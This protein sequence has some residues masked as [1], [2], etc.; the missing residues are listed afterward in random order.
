VNLKKSGFRYGI[1]SLL[2]IFSVF[3][4][5]CVSS[6]SGPETGNGVLITDFKPEFQKVYSGE[7]V[8]FMLRV[9]NIGSEKATYSKVCVVGLGNE[10]VENK[11]LRDKTCTDCFNFVT[12]EGFELLPPTE[13]VEGEEKV[14]VW[15]YTA[16]TTVPNGMKIPYTAIGRIYYYYQ[17]TTVKSITILPQDEMRRIEQTGGV[18]PAETTVF[19]RS[20]VQITIQND[21]P[22]RYWQTD[23]SGG[24]VT[25]P[26]AIKIDNVEAGF[27]LM[28]GD[29]MAEHHVNPQDSPTDVQ[30]RYYNRV[31]ARI[32]FPGDSNVELIDCDDFKDGKSVVIDL[33][34]GKTALINCKL[35]FKN[36]GDISYPVQKMIQVDAWYGY[37][38]EQS[39]SIEVIGKP[40]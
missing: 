5:G 6:G 8:N 22:I 1:L 31:K 19:S 23:D 3:A 11:N 26:L 29:G 24:S 37:L 30:D 25:F 2:V 32:T 35:K 9:K 28:S 34:E 39:A 7:P 16:P 4:S 18:L 12:G 36:I 10:W 13:N 40:V 38:I 17:S 20:P 15:H 21:G 27:G 33:W 14:C